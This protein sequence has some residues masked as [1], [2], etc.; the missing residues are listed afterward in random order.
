MVR[1]WEEMGIEVRTAHGPDDPA[2]REAADLVIPHV[3]LTVTPPSY[4][5]FLDGQPRVLNRGV[6]DISKRVI[7]EHLVEAEDGY[8]G[9]VVVKSDLNY[10]GLPEAT[11]EHRARRRTLRGRIRRRLIGDPPLQ[12]D[13]P[14]TPLA[15]VT[16]MRPTNYRVFERKQDVPPAVWDNPRLVVERF[17]PERRGDDYVIRVYFFLGDREFHQL[18]GGPEPIVKGPGQTIREPAEPNPDIV[19][20]RRR[21]GWDYGKFDYVV[22]DDG[23]VLLDANRTPGVGRIPEQ[24]ARAGRFLAPGIESVLRRPVTDLPAG[25]A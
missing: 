18:R 19:A 15:D 10:G 23:V 5:A 21:M 3:N 16:T 24:S 2:A 13:E 20:L 17:L 6:Y 25:T 8:E 1:V 22:R 11:L 4:R 7:S 12:V 9:P 14:T